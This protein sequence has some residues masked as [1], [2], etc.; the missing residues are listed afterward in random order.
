MSV[1][2]EGLAKTY[3]GRRVL[4]GL[5][6]SA[7]DGRVTGFLGRNGAGKTTTLRCLLGLVRADA[8]RCLVD[9]RPFAEL[10]HP[11]GAVGALLSQEAHHPARSGRDHLRILASASGL[12]RQRVAQVVE[13]VELSDAA[14]RPV[15]GYSLGMRQRLHLAAALLGDPATLVLDEPTNGLDPPGARWL[16]DRLQGYAAQGRCVLLSSHVLGEVS[17]TVDDVCV[18]AGGRIVAQGGLHEVMGDDDGVL[19]ET[20]LPSRLHALLAGLGATTRPVEGGAGGL[21]RLLVH[22][23]DPETIARAA[24]HHGVLLTL[25][26]PVQADLEARFLALT[27]PGGDGGGGSA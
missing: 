15:R 27:E 2:I 7:Q 20:D 21:H 22:G 17:R 18:V 13:E 11:S 16:R 14:D 26:H 3:R 25:L 19:V 6:M 10:D 4:D 5:T 23:V 12:P 8:G 9:G 24:S 1:T